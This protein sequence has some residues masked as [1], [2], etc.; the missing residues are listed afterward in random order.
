MP[1]HVHLIRHGQSTFNAAYAIDGI[2]PLHFD[3]RLTPLGLEQVAAARVEA[4]GLEPE[5]IVT[6]PLTRAIQTTIGIFGERPVLVEALHREH[7]Y[8][9]CDVGRAPADL[10]AEFPHLTFG[11]LA[12]IWWHHG[13]DAN[14]HGICIEPMDM[15]MGRV[16]DFRRWLMARPER[17]IAVIGHGTF[18]LH[19]TGERFE[20]CQRRT[21]SFD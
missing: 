20:N 2:D 14:E 8:S 10:A 7:C 11:H 1:K 21:L 13:P 16:E 17:E 6:S 9:S 19:L 15:L 5:L 3:A 4:A 18:F 12:D